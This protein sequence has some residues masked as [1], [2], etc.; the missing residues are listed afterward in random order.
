MA[1]FYDKA[2]LKNVRSFVRSFVR[3]SVRDNWRPGNRPFWISPIHFSSDFIH[4][5]MGFYGFFGFIDGPQPPPP[6]FL[7]PSPLFF[8]ALRENFFSKMG[9]A[10][11]HYILR[12][13]RE[14]I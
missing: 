4:K 6:F 11:W 12:L 1:L 13:D 3:S 8:F 7:T 14:A 10:E 9:E 5:F 2:F